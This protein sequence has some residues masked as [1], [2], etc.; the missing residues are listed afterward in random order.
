MKLTEIQ[1][2]ALQIVKDYRRITPRRFAE[3]MWPNSK[4]W[5]H[6]TKCGPS[7]VTRGGGMW[8]AAGGYLGRLRK[9]KLV[10]WDVDRYYRK[11]YHLT[12]HGERSLLESEREE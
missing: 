7:G 10:D 8:L 4:C 9:L 11:H 5:N 1:I 3:L 6:S 2:K 12:K